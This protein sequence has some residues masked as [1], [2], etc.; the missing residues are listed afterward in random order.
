VPHPIELVLP[1]EPAPVR[2]MNTVWAD[3][4][5]LHDS[6]TGVEDL[7]IFLVSTGTS[8]TAWIRVTAGHVESARRLRDALRRLAAAV[9]DADRSPAGTDLTEVDA[10]DAVN[11]AIAAAPHQLLRR[12][13]G[14]WVLGPAEEVTIDTALGCLAQEGAELVVDPAR[15]LRACHAPGCVLYFLRNHPRREWCSITC[16]NRARAARHYRRLRRAE[17]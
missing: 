15:P 11:A 16:G 3:R 12:I 7:Q 14:G 13:D 10:V 1:D 5:G 8:P 9:T 4:T 2:L 6:L 17:S